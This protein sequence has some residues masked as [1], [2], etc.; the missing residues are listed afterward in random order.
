MHQGQSKSGEK[1]CLVYVRYFDEFEVKTNHY[2]TFRIPNEESM[3]FLGHRLIETWKTDGLKPMNSCCFFVEKTFA[4]E[5]STT[6]NEFFENN[7]MKLFVTIHHEFSLLGD[8]M[9]SG[10]LKK[11][12][13]IVGQIYDFIRPIRN[14]NFRLKNWKYFLDLAELKNQNR[15]EIRW[16]FVFGSMK[17]ILNNIRPGCQGLWKI[18]HDFRNDFL[19]GKLLD[20]EFLVPLHFLHDVHESILGPLMKLT[21]TNKT[22]WTTFSKMF[23]EK[24]DLID[25]WLSTSNGVT[26]PALTNFL[27]SSQNGRFG[28]LEINTDGREKSLKIVR[29]FLKT[30]H[31]ELFQR[32]A[33]RSIEEDFLVLF[34][35]ENL[36]EN[37]KTFLHPDFGRQNIENLRKEFESFPNFNGELV[38]KEWI[39]FK[40][41]I[42]HFLEHFSISS[43]GEEFWKDFIRWQ[44]STNKFFLEQFQNL[45]FLLKISLVTQRNFV[46]CSSGVRRN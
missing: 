13:S 43:I 21:Q 42:K 9:A 12:E 32:F 25:R 34:D 30:L 11:F 37:Q 6:L 45:L 38:L 1:L 41:L 33:F 18:L 36:I 22:N 17:P 19:L 29:Y 26:G 44:N 3:K 4:T 24:Q 10:F 40:P 2:A 23:E 39:H 28:S 35:P 14:E 31:N 20:D 27:E 15:D 5:I 8:P 16:S 7:S 46:E